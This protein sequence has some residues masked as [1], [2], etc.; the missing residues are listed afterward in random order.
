MFLLAFCVSDNSLY[1][2]VSV[3]NDITVPDTLS[4]H[5]DA[6]PLS[7]QDEGSLCDTEGAEL[8]RLLVGDI[9]REG[10]G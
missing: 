10:S 1:D 6:K 9:R 2:I 8:S 3:F 7:T 4:C 5:Q